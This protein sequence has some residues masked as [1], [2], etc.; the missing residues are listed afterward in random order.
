MATIASMIVQ[1]AADTSELV[2]NVEQSNEK[3][4]EI[5][6]HMTEAV[7]S[8]ELLEHAFEKLGEIG[9]EAIRSIAE[10]FPELVEHAIEVGNSIYEMSLKTGA[11]VENLSALRY[12]ASQTGMD[13]DQFGTVLYKMEQALGSTGAKADKLQA[14]LDIL[15]LNLQELKNESPDQAFIDIMSALEAIPNRADQA[16]IGMQ[17]FGKGFKDM[18]ALTQES[19]TDLIDE[20]N[21]LGLV[22][23]TDQAAAAHAAE[24]G[25]KS[26]S[27]QLEAAA[28]SIGTIVLPAL[29]ALEQL[30]GAAFQSLLDGW[31]SSGKAFG[32]DAVSPVI[33]EIGN[34]LITATA[35]MAGFAA[36]ATE[37]L[38]GVIDWAI[39]AGEALINV[40]AVAIKVGT[41]GTVDEAGKTLLDKTQKALHDS[42]DALEL[43]KGGVD[44]SAAVAEKAFGAIEQISDGMSGKFSDAYLKAKDTIAD[45]AEKSHNAF[46][47]IGT[48]VEDAAKDSGKWLDQLIGQMDAFERESVK[49]AQTIAK[50]FGGQTVL[51]D[52]G[53]QM[54][55]IQIAGFQA[56]VEAPETA[57]QIKGAL[58]KSFNAGMVLMPDLSKEASDHMKDLLATHVDNAFTQIF[59]QDI[60][61]LLEKAFTGS[62][63]LSGAIKAIGVDVG[64]RLGNTIGDSINESLA[65]SGTGWGQG[66]LGTFANMLPGIGGAIGSLIGPL[67]SSLFS[68]GGPSQAEL[69]GRQTE[70]Q[71]EQSF[72]GFQQMMDAVGAAYEATGRSAAQAQ[73]D[74]KALF[75]AEK[76]GTAATQAMIN[77]INSAFTEQTQDAQD[78]QA[79][80]QRYGFTL[81][82]LGPTLQKQQLD[83]QVQ[84]LMNDWRL[85]VGAGIA[86]DTVNTRMASSIQDYL[87][88]AIQTG[89][90]V[91][92]AMEPILQKMIDQG[93]LTDQAGNKITD[94]SQ[95]GVSFSMTMSEGFQKV[96]DKL[97]QLLQ[98]I[99][100][101]PAAIAKIPTSIDIAANVNWDTGAG[102]PEALPMAAGGAGYVSGPTLFYSAG[103]ESFA[104][105]GEGRSFGD[106]SAVLDQLRKMPTA[107]DMRRLLRDAIAMAA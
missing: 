55:D 22:M 98:K 26:F 78:L 35:A 102:L 84:Q 87:T 50:S 83:Q 58:T 19:I 49:A 93:L 57:Q 90:E 30:A 34:G 12:V 101:V 94:L 45:F 85:L 38:K 39:R 15:G 1:I 24:V 64:S 99:G 72:G 59:E 3:L 13:F 86:V 71:F 53:I 51:R 16:A 92:D 18:A 42:Y 97:D 28:M 74:V 76:N 2:R 25:W 89:Q 61:N 107:D 7:F 54:G 5:G 44:N 103:H 43:F 75:D 106:S 62:G 69:Q 36:G 77:Q 9:L 73:A 88:K 79:A 67:F 56:R 23:S 20:A 10:A 65:E 41:L 33:I 95:I 40:G 6:E 66:I 82:E 17:V 27:M 70:S 29:I 63:G 31:K 14:S 32:E 4:D 96:V 81:A 46:G 68:I 21:Q 104:F 105:S 47:G 37:G 8:G 91:P 100:M 11:S 80:V 60:P 48:D 52:I